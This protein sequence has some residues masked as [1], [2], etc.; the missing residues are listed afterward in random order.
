VI[1][2]EV[3]PDD[4]PGLAPLMAALGYPT[5]EARLRAGMGAIMADPGYRTVVAEDGG[6]LVGMV[7]MRRG[8][9]YEAGTFV[10]LAASPSVRVAGRSGS[11]SRSTQG[12]PPGRSTR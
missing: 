8:L 1:L 12:E 5:D 4:V 9:R 7:G 10:Q 6:R 3:T 11:N 2:R